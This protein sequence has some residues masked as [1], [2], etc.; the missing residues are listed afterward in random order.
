[1]DSLRL[2]KKKIHTTLP[3]L[4]LQPELAGW[5]ATPILLDRI[6]SFD[7]KLPYHIKCVRPHLSFSELSDAANGD[8]D[9]NLGMTLALFPRF[10]SQSM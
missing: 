7:L 4:S 6:S 3:N 8:P 5:L 2:E 1:M 10:F 9:L